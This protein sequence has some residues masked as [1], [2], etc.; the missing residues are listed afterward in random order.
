MSKNISGNESKWRELIF[1]IIGFIFTI[2]QSIAGGTQGNILLLHQGWIQINTIIFYAPCNLQ[3]N[4]EIRL[5]GCG[6]GNDYRKMNL[7]D[8]EIK[9]PAVVQLYDKEQN[10]YLIRYNTSLINGDN[11]L[12]IPIPR[13]SQKILRLEVSYE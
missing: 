2:S 4:R 11:T 10:T 5:T 1:F 3:F 9:T 13:S 8:S 12:H 6:A 7:F